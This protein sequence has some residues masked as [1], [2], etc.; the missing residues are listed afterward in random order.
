LAPFCRFG[1]F[2]GS[3]GSFN[4]PENLPGDFA[5]RSAKDICG[6]LRVEIKHIHEVFRLKVG[7]SVLH[8][9]AVQHIAD[10]GG[11]RPVKGDLYVE[12]IIPVKE[13]IINDVEDLSL[14]VVPILPRKL[15]CDHIQHLKQR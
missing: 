13:R 15:V 6:G 11:C 1:A 7:F 12:F 9:A 8:T 5:D 14:A 3:Y 4:L 10:A 2:I